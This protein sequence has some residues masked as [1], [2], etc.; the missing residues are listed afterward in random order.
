[1]DEQLEALAGQELEVEQLERLLANLSD[2]VVLTQEE[3]CKC[4]SFDLECNFYCRCQQLK[5]IGD[6]N[7]SE[8]NDTRSLIL[9]VRL[10][11]T[12]RS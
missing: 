5:V 10:D 7:P 2:E 8:V 12:I 6:L 9:S 3:V 1:M 11:L 4:N